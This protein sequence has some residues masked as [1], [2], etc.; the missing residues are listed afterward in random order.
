[1]T[2]KSEF[3]L[4]NWVKN[5]AA[6]TPDG[7][8]TGIGDDMAVLNL[9]DQKILITTDTLLETVH[10]QLKGSDTFFSQQQPK[11]GAGAFFSPATLQQVGYKAMACSLSD[12]A[13]MAS[14][15]W[16]AVVAAA[17]PN[18]FTITD[19]QQLH[20]GLQQA[21]TKYN[22]PIVGGDT[23]SWDQP[24]AITVT[25][26]ARA[27]TIEPVLRS[28]AQP[29]DTICVTGSLGASLAGRHLTFEPR[30]AEARQLAQHFNLNSMID[31]SDGLSSDLNHI[32]Q[33]SNT[34]AL[35]DAAAIPISPAA[36][37]TKDPL[38]A[39]LHDGEDFELLFTLNP[40]NAQK[41]LQSWPQLSQIPITPIGQITPPN[42]NQ[43]QNIQI[44]HPNQPPTPLPPKGYQHFK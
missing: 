18:H 30:I 12:C 34:N 16:F 25:M 42:P 4:I 38:N 17:L 32:C 36:Q 29:G 41:L 43:P 10:F 6:P 33:Q 9:A 13:A 1:M 15:P 37:K 26:L 21:A 20:H 35:L 40:N 39:A 19:A 8:K 24:L 31:L 44:K 2:N 11:K 5:Q 23:T 27:D 14:S 22:C 28:G 7:L 3:E